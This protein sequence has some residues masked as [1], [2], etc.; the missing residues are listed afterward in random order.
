MMR[1]AFEPPNR[2]HYTTL[3]AVLLLP[4]IAGGAGRLPDRRPVLRPAPVAVSQGGA[5][6]AVVDLRPYC[7]NKKQ[8][9]NADSV[10]FGGIIAGRRHDPE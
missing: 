6:S 3:T 4:L 9:L 10:A 7:E 2:T 1:N 5:G 8:L